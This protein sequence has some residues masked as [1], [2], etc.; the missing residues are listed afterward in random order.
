MGKKDKKRIKKEIPFKDKG[1]RVKEVVNVIKKLNGLGLNN[2]Y[3]GIEEFKIILKKF[4]EDGIFKQGKIDLPGT[5][6][7][8]YYSF[9][10]RS[11]NEISIELKYNENI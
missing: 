3:E 4:V 10:E 8:I 5:K 1:E 2:N 11:G 7:Q 9:P 6:R